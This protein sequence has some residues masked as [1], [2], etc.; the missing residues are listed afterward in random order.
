MEPVG[1]DSGSLILLDTSTWIPS[2]HWSFPCKLASV[3]FGAA[4]GVRLTL[5]GGLAAYPLSPPASGASLTP[6]IKLTLFA[7]PERGLPLL[8]QVSHSVPCVCPNQG[9]EKRLRLI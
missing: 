4:S 5:E 6:A 7:A 1:L 3:G 2:K 9:Q 8:L